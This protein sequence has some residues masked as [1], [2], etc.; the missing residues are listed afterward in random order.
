[1]TIMSI[2]TPRHNSGFTIQSILGDTDKEK[3]NSQDKEPRRKRKN[4][5][6]SDD[7]NSCTQNRNSEEHFDPCRVPLP[8]GTYDAFSNDNILR[9]LQ[10]AQ[11]GHYLSQE[12]MSR[13]QDDFRTFCIPGSNERNNPFYLPLPLT[14][15]FHSS[16]QGG[17]SNLLFPHLRKP[18]R[19]RTAFSPSQ[20]LRLE[21]A[22]E[23]NHYVVGQERKQL[24]VGLA[25][26]E[27]QV[28]VWFQNRR[29]KHKRIKAE[30][31]MTRS[32]ARSL[33]G[34]ANSHP[35][36]YNPSDSESDIEV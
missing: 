21:H 4:S 1:M 35:S 5:T 12:Y 30:D 3:T 36:Q 17:N 19:M 2:S 15:N 23:N 13:T 31:E 8:F 20:L 34:Q 33:G 16:N 29:T 25:L 26:T 10:Y 14:N 9:K 6:E 32:L 28:K 18:K 11:Y 27:T 22:F 7:C 24:A